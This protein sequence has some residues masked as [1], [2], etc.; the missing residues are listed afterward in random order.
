VYIADNVEIFKDPINK[1]LL[2]AANNT[3][4]AIANGVIARFVES[5]GG[6]KKRA[7]KWGAKKSVGNNGSGHHTNSN[8]GGGG[9]D[10]G[11][12][13]GIKKKW[14]Q[15]N[16]SKVIGLAGVLLI[17]IFVLVWVIISQRKDNTTGTTTVKTPTLAPTRQAT[18]GPHPADDPN[19]ANIA[20]ANKKIE[21]EMKK[22]KGNGNIQTTTV[23]IGTGTR[24]DKIP[25]V[26]NLKITAD[27]ITIQFD[28]GRN[29]NT[30]FFVG[31]KITVTAKVK[32]VKAVGGKWSFGDGISAEGPLNPIVVE[33]LSPF[34]YSNAKLT[35]TIDGQSHD[36]T[37]RI[38]RK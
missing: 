32:G 37:I 20:A 2:Q 28:Q 36:V 21:N 27:D 30:I 22:G 17:G 31:D 6:S 35:Y 5:G 7:I 8:N 33:I 23:Q 15:P 29:M 1:V 12:G 14:W 26:E 34:K 18:H 24:S 25:K 13:G 38:S 11:H 9:F 3:I 16:Y 4:F 10:G 19:A